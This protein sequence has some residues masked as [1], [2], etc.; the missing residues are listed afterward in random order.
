MATPAGVLL[1]ASYRKGE[2]VKRQGDRE[3]VAI[4]TGNPETR[5]KQVVEAVNRRL[6]ATRKSVSE[7][8]GVSCVPCEAGASPSE[9][10]R[11]DSAVR[12]A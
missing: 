2:V 11:Y 8:R 6:V 4:T 9:A 3:L 12:A 1:T 10:E 7:R 5:V